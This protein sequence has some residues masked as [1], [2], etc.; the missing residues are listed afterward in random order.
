[1]GIS[2]EVAEKEVDDFNKFYNSASQEV[3]DSYGSILTINKY[4]KCCKCGESF[5]KME[6]TIIKPKE[7]NSTI[8]AII[9][10]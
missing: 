10:D 4:E 5:N 1:M 7:K 9:Y 6:L 3:K 2:R 8:Q